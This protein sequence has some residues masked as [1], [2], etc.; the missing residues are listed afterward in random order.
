VAKTNPCQIC[1]QV[2]AAEFTLSAA[3]PQV[4]WFEQLAVNICEGCLLNAAYQ[5]T[6]QLAE[7]AARE[8]TQPGPGALE[9]IESDEQL[10][11]LGD[12]PGPAPGPKSRRQS[13]PASDPEV[14][15]AA[16]AAPD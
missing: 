13:P 11:P 4:S 14:P 16:T 8:E 6:V 10:E 15:A 2:P 7:L 5:R 3:V 9:Q 1:G 12:G